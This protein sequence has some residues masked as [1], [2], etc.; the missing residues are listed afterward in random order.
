M[1]NYNLLEYSEEKSESDNQIA[2]NEIQIPI[3]IFN[4]ESLSSL[5]TVTKYLKEETNLRI[6][7]I[8]VALNRS[9]KTIWNAYNESKIKMSYKLEIGHD[10]RIFIPSVVLCDRNVSFLEAI[11]EFLRDNFN[12][13]YC[14][15]A[16]LLCKDQR[17]IWTVYYR[18]KKKRKVNQIKDVS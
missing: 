3:E 17:T 16:P 5:E 1:Q 8:A 7:D 13:R 12:L 10:T 9:Q 15:I 14:Q 2:N 18:A 11:T 4:N 6:K